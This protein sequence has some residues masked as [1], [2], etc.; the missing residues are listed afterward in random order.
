MVFS[1]LAGIVLGL[2][3]FGGLY[4]TTKKLPASKSP[5]LLMFLSI[6]LRMII[7]IGGLYIVFNGEIIRLLVGIIGVF[8]AKYI[9]VYSVK[10]KVI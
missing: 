4:F 2:I 10:R 7:L 8:V 5:A 6:T 3:F 9:I 1:F